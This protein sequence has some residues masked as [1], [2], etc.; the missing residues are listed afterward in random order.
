MAE[1][2]IYLVENNTA[3]VI[4]L[5][6]RRK[7]KKVDL[8]GATVELI[9]AKESDGSVVNTG[10]QTC[11]ITDAARGIVQYAQE[12]GDFDGTQIYLGD[13]KVTHSSGKVEIWRDQLRVDVR[14]KIGG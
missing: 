12:S 2:T 8:T 6:L 13:V 5:R 7:G 1:R 10:H 14:D 3:P 11:T 9:L 4:E